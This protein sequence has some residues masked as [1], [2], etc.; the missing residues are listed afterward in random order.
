M[1]TLKTL[2]TGVVFGSLLL[3]GCGTAPVEGDLARLQA[4]LDSEKTRASE[5]LSSKSTLESTLS[6][7]DRKVDELMAKLSQADAGSSNLLPPGAKAGQCYARVFTPPVYETTTKSVL[8]REAS[9]TIRVTESSYE[10]VQER[11]LVREAGKEL[12]VIP[13]RYDWVEERVLVKEAS[14][15]LEVVP[16][17]YETIE[18][19][20]LVR[21]ASTAW[22]KG[23]GPI[24]KI[25]HMTGEIMCLVETPAEYRTVRTQKLVSAASTRKISIPEEYATVKKRLMVEGP[26]TVEVEVPAVYDTVSIR[27]MVTAPGEQRIEIPATYK[28]VSERHMVSDGQ[29]EWQPILC[30]TNTTADIVSRLQ[31]A[32]A[33]K[34]YNPGRIDG[35]IGHQTM[36]AATSYQTDNGL[37]SGKLT[38]ETLQ[39][40][41]VVSAN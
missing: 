39:R 7:R 16:A 28:T 1:N 6:D 5:L 12:Q 25:N 13:A 4:E 29:L 41:N 9:E 2:A 36:R 24:E 26:K 23:R 34:G 15:R 22:K 17:Q 11:I 32:L 30:E 8:A 21:P 37:P 10:T 40:L 38:I 18:E 27:K 35:V 14:E 31:N 19:Q 20:M 3:S 33:A